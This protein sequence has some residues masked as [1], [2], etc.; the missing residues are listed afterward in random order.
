[1]TFIPKDPE[2]REYDVDGN[3]IK[4][5]RW[6]YTWNAENRLEK[7]ETRSNLPAGVPDITLEF[8]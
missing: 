5:G 7:V 1:M 4:D 3:L 8:K 2:A 6:E